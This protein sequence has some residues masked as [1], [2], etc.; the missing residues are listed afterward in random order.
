VTHQQWRALVNSDEHYGKHFFQ[1]FPEAALEFPGR[2]AKQNRYLGKVGS[3]SAAAKTQRLQEL[4]ISYLL[5]IHM[6]GI[7]GHGPDCFCSACTFDMSRIDP[8]LQLNLPP[9]VLRSLVSILRDLSEQHKIELRE[10]FM[11][12]LV[13]MF[14]LSVEV[15]HSELRTRFGEW[16][17]ALMAHVGV[18]P[19]ELLD[20]EGS[21]KFKDQKEVEWNA[22][23]KLL[24]LGDLS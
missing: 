23:L 18:E 2:V 20:Y 19:V 7:N 4:T 5:W 8:D 16:D 17:K 3:G 22:W 12:G 9:D 1:Y 14:R 11:E 15:N 24:V 6:F 21:R 10:R 13:D